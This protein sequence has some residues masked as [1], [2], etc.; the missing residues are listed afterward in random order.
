MR[1][2]HPSTNTPV[3]LPGTRNGIYNQGGYRAP[4]ILSLL[5]SFQASPQER[6]TEIMGFVPSG[7]STE[8][9]HKLVVYSTGNGSH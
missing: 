7:I 2:D 8:T 6:V 3:A 1:Q 5:P 9:L 4:S